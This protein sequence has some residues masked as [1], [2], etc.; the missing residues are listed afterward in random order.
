MLDSTKSRLKLDW[1]P[2]WHLE[3]ALSK[4]VDWYKISGQ[5]TDML[6]FTNQQLE[7]YLK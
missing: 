6:E 1:R 7:E 4:I 2:K 5:N 3:E